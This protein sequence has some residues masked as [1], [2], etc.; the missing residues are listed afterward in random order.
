MP[1]SEEREVSPDAQAA[2]EDWTISTGWGPDWDCDPDQDALEDQEN[3]RLFAEHGEE[4]MRDLVR[5]A[6]DRLPG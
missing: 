2:S 1:D 4:I 6:D 3:E 5:Q